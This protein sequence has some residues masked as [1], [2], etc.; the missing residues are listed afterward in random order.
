[1]YPVSIVSCYYPLSQSKHSVEEYMTW[2]LQFLTKVDTPII[3]FSEGDA[4]RFMKEIREQ[5]GLADRFHL[6]QKPFSELKF[7]TPEWIQTWK[8]QVEMS[9]YKHLHNQELFRIW[10]N[11]AFFVEEAIQKNPFQSDFFVWC[12]AGCWRDS[13]VSRIFGPS[14]PSPTKLQA[15]KLHIL[16]ISSVQPYINQLMNPAIQTQEDCVTKID[17]RFKAIVGGTI[18]IGDKAAW[19]TWIPT[20]ES[21]LTLFI[22]NNLFAGDDQAVITSAALWLRKQESPNA[23]LFIDAPKGNGFVEVDDVRM[24][25]MWFAFQIYFSPIMDCTFSIY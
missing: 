13:R 10:S 1:M 21:T 5:A 24:G 4:Y 23:P 9:N 6:I 14:W 8:N 18:L 22:K 20:F 17:T 3:M 19:Q 2:I 12:D 25:D 11:K 16:A 15:N 7:S